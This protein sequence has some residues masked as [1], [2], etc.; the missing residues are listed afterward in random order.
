MSKSQHIARNRVTV[1]FGMT[2]AISWTIWSLSSVVS[3]GDRD[4]KLVIDL[5][6]AY[7]PALA[8]IFVSGLVGPEPS[9]VRSVKRWA[10]FVPIFVIT[11][12]IW[13][14][15]AEKFGPFSNPILFASK[16][17]MAALVAF[18]ISGIF[19]RKSGV[20]SLLLPLT[21]WRVNP[22][23]YLVVIL[24]YPILIVLTTVLVVLLGI[25][26]PVEQYSVPSQPWHQLLL[27][28]LLGYVQTLL[29]QGPLNEEPGWRGLALPRLQ[30]QYGSLVASLIVGCAWSIWHAPLYF[31]GLYA[32]GVEAM[33]MRFF[34]NVP[35]A[36]VFTWVYN[37][38]RGSLL[39]SIL[40]HTSLNFQQDISSIVLQALLG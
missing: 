36:F 21:T 10:L 23:W 34:W 29:F 13:L 16:L 11:N 37:R 6:G 32:G 9:G 39:I 2:F 15:S 30:D 19:S 25:P 1:F 22:V 35:L 31:N 20:R 33:M 27:G 24:G 26:V 38:T 4:A 7:G 17:V 12:L 8:A 40:L 14:L 18:V 3:A 5:T 28:L